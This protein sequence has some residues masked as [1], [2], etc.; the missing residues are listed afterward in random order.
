M[1]VAICFKPFGFLLLIFYRP[2]DPI[3]DQSGHHFALWTMGRSYRFNIGLTRNAMP[4]PTGSATGLHII[5]VS[6][7]NKTAV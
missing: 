5:Q 7:I 4:P 6:K 2:G 1:E 3:T